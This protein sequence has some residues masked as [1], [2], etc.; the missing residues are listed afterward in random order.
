MLL[1]SIRV[2]V[3]AKFD[4]HAL[5]AAQAQ[6]RVSVLAHAL[7]VIVLQ[8]F[9]PPVVRVELLAF[10]AVCPVHAGQ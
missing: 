1:F 9:P 3:S 5:V 4:V 8:V 6:A 2:V 7:G 10:H